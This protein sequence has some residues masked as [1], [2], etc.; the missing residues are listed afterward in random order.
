MSPEPPD[1]APASAPVQ[2]R[3]FISAV[4]AEFKSIRQ[5]VAETV[6][7]LGYQAVSMEN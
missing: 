1:P 6:E 7:K 3:V 2:P 4:S 5:Q